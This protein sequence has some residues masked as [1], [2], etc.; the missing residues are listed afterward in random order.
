MRYEICR[1]AVYPRVRTR[2]RGV[3]LIRMGQRT[4][5]GRPMASPVHAPGKVR[6]RPPRCEGANSRRVD[7]VR[8][9]LRGTM[10]NA[11][12]CPKVGLGRDG[13]VQGP[14]TD[15][16]RGPMRLTVSSIRV[17]IPGL[18]ASSRPFYGA[19]ENRVKQKHD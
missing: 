18:S 11:C 13:W 6:G 17:W 4:A 14:R 19:V 15:V 5:V 1:R 3:F 2:K 16:P 8:P 12:P 7:D 10:R 9:A